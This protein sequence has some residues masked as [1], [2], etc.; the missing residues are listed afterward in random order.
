MSSTAT[1]ISCGVVHGCAE[2]LLGNVW[3]RFEFSAS[4]I[5]VVWGSFVFCLFSLQLIGF[6]YKRSSWLFDPRQACRKLT[7]LMLIIKYNSYEYNSLKNSQFR[8]WDISFKEKLG[9]IF[10]LRISLPVKYKFPGRKST[11]SHF[12]TQQRVYFSSFF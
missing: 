12:Y 1:A 3:S 10:R 7:A 9:N 6:S 11:T 5:G 2:A 8:D 4:E